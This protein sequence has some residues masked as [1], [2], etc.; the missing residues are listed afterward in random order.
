MLRGLGY[1]K[2]EIEDLLRDLPDPIDSERDAVA[3]VQRGLTFSKLT[4]RRGGSP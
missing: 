1:S 3:L 2:E 4:D